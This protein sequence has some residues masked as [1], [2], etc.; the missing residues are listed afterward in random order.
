MHLHYLEFVTHNVDSVCAAFAKA[1]N[2][3][4]SEPIPELGNACTAPLAG[5]W[6]VGVRAPMHESEEPV[7]RPYWLVDDIEIALAAALKAGAELAHA[8]LAIADHGTFAIYFHGGTQQ[9]LWQI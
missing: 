7:T 8:P 5:G 3:A 1:N 9:G 2:V 4:F 6:R